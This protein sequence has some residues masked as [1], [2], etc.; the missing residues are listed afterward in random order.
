MQLSIFSQKKTLFVGE[1]KSIQLPG[2]TAPFQVFKGHTDLISTLEEGTIIY[3][4][5]DEE[6]L[7]ISIQEGIV[8]IEND[9]ITVLIKEL[10]K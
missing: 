4:P 8:K 6:S 2:S 7:S 3:Q 9:K 1:I 10:A 5:S